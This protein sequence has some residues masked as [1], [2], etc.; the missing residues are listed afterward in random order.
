MTVTEI[1]EKLES[2]GNE[3]VRA[4]NKKQGARDDQFGVKMGDIRAL[5]KSIKTNHQL[6][7]E[8]WATGN[9][10]A[11]FLA[12]LIIEPK[13]LSVEEIDDMVRSEQFNHVAD[14]FSSYILKEHADREQLRLLWMKSDHPMAAR[15]GWSLTAGRI[16]RS[17]EGL[18][19]PALLDRIEAEMPTAPPETQWTMNFA[20]AYTGIHHPELRERALQVGERLGIYR[21]YP[22][23]KGC[24]SPFA[25]IW[26]NEMVRRQG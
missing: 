20:L 8:L 18:D 2:L 22:T 17:A 19:I 23:S 26:I 14:W 9:I 10:E 3:K 16:A 5:A 7:K 24:T 12:V 15:A 6:A 13:K 25:P 4:I 21:D 1:L 11:R